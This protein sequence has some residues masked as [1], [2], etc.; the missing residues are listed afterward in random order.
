MMKMVTLLVVVVV[1]S[2]HYVEA[3][4]CFQR[5]ISECG[6]SCFTRI[7]QG[8]ELEFGCNPQ[9]TDNG[10]TAVEDGFAYVIH[11]NHDKCNP[12]SGSCLSLSFSLLVLGALFTLLL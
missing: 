2:L 12:D 7:P 11:C 1:T 8:E 9:V 3:I 10:E 4:Q 5:T 6:G